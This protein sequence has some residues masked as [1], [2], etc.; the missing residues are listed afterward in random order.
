[1]DNEDKK[2][3]QYL[4]IF[5]DI[6][7][8][9]NKTDFEEMYHINK[10]FHEEFEKNQNKDMEH[11]VYF[12]KIYTFSDCAYIFYKF[13]DEISNERKNLSKLFTVAL[14]NCEPI[15]LRFLKEKIIFR[16]GISYG[17]AYVDSH[18]SM[19]FGNAV[20]QAYKLESKIAIH[21]RIVIDSC[22]ANEVIENIEEVKYKMLATNPEYVPFVGMGIMPPMPETGDGIVE[23][24][25]DGE[26]IF[27]YLHFPENEMI[28]PDI[29]LSGQDFIQELIQY[30]YE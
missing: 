19:F 20:N 23:M 17:D 16:G 21:P 28:C 29:Y 12:R 22:V 10:I 2:F 7:G 14:C 26:F 6:L 1:M 9:Q 8:S 27:N 5:V 11:T 3:S 24:D 15:F 13:K 25:L 4:V 30:C 18:R